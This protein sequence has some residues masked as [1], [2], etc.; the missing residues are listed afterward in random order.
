M[1]AVRIVRYA[2]SMRVGGCTRQVTGW[3]AVEARAEEGLNDVVTEVK[4][5]SEAPGMWRGKPGGF[6]A[7]S[8][9]Q[10]GD[11]GA[12]YARPGTGSPGRRGAPPPF[13]R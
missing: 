6:Q 10:L 9:T 11:S 5:S 4:A 2:G 3:K 8:A 1:Q 7:D 13:G 12:H